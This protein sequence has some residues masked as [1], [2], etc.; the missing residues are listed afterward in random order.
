MAV[1]YWKAIGMNQSDVLM[2]GWELPPHNSGGLGV[3][4]Y[5][6]AKSLASNGITIAFT[7]PKKLRSN[8]PFM[9]IV[10][11][12][13]PGVDITAINAQLTSYATQATFSHAFSK[14][15]QP[16][17]SP[18]IY[19]EALRYGRV[20]AT[21][22]QSRRFN[23]IH[24]HDWMTYPAAMQTK[25]ISHKPWIAHVHA[26]EYDRSGGSVDNRIVQI[27]Y[28]GLQDADK[29]ITVSDYTK[30]K[31]M[32]HYHVPEEKISVVHNGVDPIE[33]DA[34]DVRRIFP[35]DQI[36]L[37]VGRLTFQKGV[38][39]LLNAAKI[40]L[41]T[42]PN[43]VFVIAGS[44]DQEKSLIMQAAYLG[45]GH[46]IIFAGHLRGSQLRSLYRMAN[47][48]VMPSVSEPYGIVALEAIANGTPTIIS[49]QSGVSETI[50]HIYKVDFWDIHKLAQQISHVLDFP[51]LAKEINSLAQVE[52]R[53][54]SWNAAAQKIISVYQQ[55]QS[56]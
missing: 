23:L 29:I 17:H 46:R 20:A 35:R 43:T 13:I 51:H 31:V 44:G 6:M 42:H 25:A 37:F 22:A 11:P 19:D 52:A 41:Q 15:N 54:L 30:Q 28:Q 3:A 27:E 8:L 12:Y 40:V 36:V 49:K 48:F 4:C 32:N 5:G 7:L 34:L 47:V 53:R 55:V 18:T 10:S 24:A 39:Y 1:L 9:K 45:I 56:N 21:W 50:S 14:A 38:D 33:F 26:T 16:P 2:Y